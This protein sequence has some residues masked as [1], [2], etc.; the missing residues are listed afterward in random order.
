MLYLLIIVVIAH[1][2]MGNQCMGACKGY[3][4]DDELDNSSPTNLLYCPYSTNSTDPYGCLLRGILY[5]GYCFTQEC[6]NWQSDSQK[7]CSDHCASVSMGRYAECYGG[8]NGF[9]ICRDQKTPN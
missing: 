3:V 9:C 1:L 6:G 5:N 4:C 8:L 7:F 2:I